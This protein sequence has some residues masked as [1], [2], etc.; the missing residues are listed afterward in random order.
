MRRHGSCRHAWAQGNAPVK[1]VLGHLRRFVEIG[2]DYD[3]TCCVEPRRKLSKRDYDEVRDLL[4]LRWLPCTAAVKGIA[5]KLKR[6]SHWNLQCL[7][8]DSVV[9]GPG[10]GRSE[11]KRTSIRTF[12]YSL[13]RLAYWC[14]C[15]VLRA[16]PGLC[17]RFPFAA[18]PSVLPTLVGFQTPQT[19]VALAATLREQHLVLPTPGGDDFLGLQ[20]QCAAL[21]QHD[22]LRYF[23][24]MGCSD[25]TLP[26]AEDVHV[27]LR[28][29]EAT[30]QSL[31]AESLPAGA[32][33]GARL[34]RRLS[35]LPFP[36]PGKQK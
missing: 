27:L 31:F 32:L 18:P 11:R 14:L 13:L 4:Q 33:V 26:P 25:A 7:P 20:L 3:S 29:R 21:P 23:L 9:E 36:W 6:Q 35:T 10:A 2:T 16:F 15:D 19:L 24:I 17:V 30:A 34:W 28:W 5:R 12:F 8:D 22:L 1:A